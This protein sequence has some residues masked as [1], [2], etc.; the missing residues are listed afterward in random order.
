[1]K[2]AGDAQGLEQVP[3]GCRMDAEGQVLELKECT[4][5]AGVRVLPGCK[6]SVLGLGQ[7][8]MGCRMGAEGQVQLG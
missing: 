8:P 5:A 2:D 4:M 1:M 7:V 3:M 6:K